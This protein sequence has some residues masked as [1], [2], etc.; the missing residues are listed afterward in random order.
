[1]LYDLDY[2][3]VACCRLENRRKPR[4]QPFTSKGSMW[5]VSVDGHDKLCGYQKSTFP[6]GVYGFIDTF[7]RKI[8]SL[9]VMLSNSDPRVIGKQYFD[10]LY[11]LKMM[12][13]F[14]RCDKG[15]ETGKMASIHCYLISDAEQSMFDDP[16]ESIAFGPS[17]TNKIE[18]WWRDLH[19]RLE[20]FF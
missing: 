20:K 10:L 1:M 5:V 12:P 16:V 3:G 13:V 9:R 4:N 7:S 8:L 6:L 19:E 14:L 11:E 15:T 18:R 2:E 17:T